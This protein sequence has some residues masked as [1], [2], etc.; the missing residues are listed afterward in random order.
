MSNWIK[1]L[2]LFVLMSGLFMAIG[3]LFGQ[4]LFGRDGALTGVAVFFAGAMI[5]NLVMY[6][7][8]GSFVVRHASNAPL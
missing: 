8:S 5:L 2:W 7:F 1:T 6:W 4:Y 3:G